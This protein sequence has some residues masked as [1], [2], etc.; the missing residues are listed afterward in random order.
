METNRDL[1]SAVAALM[2]EQRNKQA[3]SLEQYLSSLRSRAKRWAKEENLSLGAFYSLLAE[4]FSPMATNAKE[5]ATTQQTAK[6]FSDWDSMIHRQIQDLQQMKARGQLDDKMNYFG[7]KAPGGQQWYNFDPCTY[8]ECATEGCFGGWEEGDETGRHY[9]P[10][11]VAVTT[12][13]GEIISCDP[14]EAERPT[15]E[16]GCVSWDQFTDFLW[17]GQHYE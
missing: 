15:V 5:S 13:D 6:G 3:I 10:G 11:K 9:V 12:K 8:L 7:I 1:Y 17:F 16:I 4:A 2:E 14:R